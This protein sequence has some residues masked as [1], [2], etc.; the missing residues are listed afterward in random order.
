MIKEKELH[1]K[2][3]FNDKKLFACN[4][5]MPKALAILNAII[6]T[7]DQNR[8]LNLIELRRFSEAYNSKGGI[9][10]FIETSKKIQR[11]D[12]I[13][14]NASRYDS[15]YLSKKEKKTFV[16]FSCQ[17]P[18]CNKKIK[19]ILEIHKELLDERYGLIEKSLPKLLP[20]FIYADMKQLREVPCTYCKKIFFAV[21]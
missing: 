3:D 16:H 6:I 10:G 8:D 2:Y 12:D 9:E 17:C 18:N 7:K 13:P 11:N 4:D 5:C 20:A 14:N 15:F 19:S 21:K 1:L